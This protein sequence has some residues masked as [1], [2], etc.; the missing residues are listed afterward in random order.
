MTILSL[1]FQIA[2]F[3]VL[4]RCSKVISTAYAPDLSFFYI[5]PG[6]Y[7][8]RR[9]PIRG[10]NWILGNFA[11]M[12][13]DLTDG[14]GWRSLGDLSAENTP[15]VRKIGTC[16]TISIY[17]GWFLLT[18]KYSDVWYTD[19]IFLCNLHKNQFSGCFNFWVKITH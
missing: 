2:E 13:V 7:V 6:V 15:R 16:G 8:M 4:C 9:V 1:N 3:G 12:C 19:I 5:V 10:A 17:C 11:Q 18:T 14:A